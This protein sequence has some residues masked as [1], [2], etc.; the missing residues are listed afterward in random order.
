MRWLGIDFGTKRIG[1]ALSDGAGWAARGLET[2]ERRGGE[3]DLEAIARI[4]R[5]Q[6]VEALVVGLPLNMDGTEGRMATLARRFAEA[7]EAR[8][9]CPVHL[10]DE[11][12]TSHAA[13][14]VLLEARGHKDR[15][16]VDQVAAA[17]I[18]EGFLEREAP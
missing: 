9:G 17:L 11:R 16:L 10:F 6:E 3:R 14:G 12:L 8:L 7:L 15:K 18:L 13:E 2:L 4:V 5:E 1:L